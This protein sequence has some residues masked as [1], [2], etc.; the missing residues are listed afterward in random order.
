MNV[1]HEFLCKA[2]VLNRSNPLGNGKVPDK[3]A[4]FS[5]KDV[6]ESLEVSV[7]SVKRWCDRGK[8]PSIRTVGGHRRIT[9]SGLRE[10]LEATGQTL[11]NPG[12]LGIDPVDLVIGTPKKTRHPSVRGE[13][14][15]PIQAEFRAALAAGDEAACMDLLLERTRQGFSK[16]EAAEDLIADAMRGMGDAWDCGELEVYQ[17]RRSCTIC[18]RLISNLRESL[19]DLD[20]SACVA[21]GAAPESDPYQLPTALVELALRESGWNATNLGNNL[22]LASLIQAAREYEPRLLW[23]SVTAI[24]D[25]ARFVRDEN[26]LASSLGEDVSLIVGGQALDDGLRPKLRY[27]AHCDGLRHLLELASIL[28]RNVS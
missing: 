9:L 19:P 23:L 10:F 21:I 22:P 5:P 26:K 17:E 14:R 15:Q 11:S 24:D 27:T 2:I 25:P 1:L 13:G 20:E 7:S 8:I 18:T 16:A 6:A 28:K 3:P 12:A 4:H